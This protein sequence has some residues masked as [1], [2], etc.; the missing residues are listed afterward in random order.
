MT[1]PNPE[2]DHVAIIGA[3]HAGLQAAQALRAGGWAGPI[4]LF[5]AE[6]DLPYQ[7]PDLSK[8]FLLEDRPDPMAL[9]AEAFFTGNDIALHRSTT[10]TALN[11][12]ARTLVAN[13]EVHR[14]DRLILATGARARTLPYD[15]ANM[16]TLRDL[17]DARAV[18]AAL[19]PGAHIAVIG[20]GFIGLEVAAAARNHGATVTV[21]EAAP[22]CLA[23]ALPLE[24]TEVLLNRH[25][26]AEVDLRI[27]CGVTGH[28]MTGDRITALTLTDGSRIACDMVVVGIGC[29]ANTDLAEMAGLTIA[30]G[31]IAVDGQLR[32]SDPAIMA[33]GDC[34]SFSNALVPGPVRLESIQNATDQARHAAAVLLGETGDFLTMP[35]F[36]S[37]QYELKLQMAGFPQPDAPMIQRSDPASG[38]F[39]L[40]QLDADNRLVAAYSLNAVADHVAARKLIGSDSVLDPGR[41]ADPGIRLKDAVAEPVPSPT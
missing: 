21:I 36:W 19:K 9:K 27:G 22:R 29:D 20:G 16:A 18:R 41:A 2:T 34:A 1:A 6:P 13:G 24:M 14:W 26:A 31:G 30:A 4:S 39:S 38:A 32:S 3:S 11:A 7:R 35:W 17:P 10:V 33:I 25:R 23:R 40:L 28:E 37:H 5:S 12:G 15:A 8:G